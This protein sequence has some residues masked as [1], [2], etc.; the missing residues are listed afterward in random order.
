MERTRK[1]GGEGRREGRRDAEGRGTRR[2]L[3]REGGAQ[4]ALAARPC[5][6]ARSQRGLPRPS[7]RPPPPPQPLPLARVIQ[8][9]A[10][11]LRP[12]GFKERA[13][14]DFFFRRLRL[15]DTRRF[16]DAYPFV[17]PCG[18]EMNYVA[19]EDTPVVFHSLTADGACGRGRA[20]GTAGGRAGGRVG[21]R[22]ARMR[23][24]ERA[25]GRAGE[26]VGSRAKSA[27]A[28]PSA[29]QNAVWGG[30]L[31]YPFDPRTLFFG[32]NGRLYHPSPL[33]PHALVRSALALEL[34]R[35]AVPNEH[36]TLTMLWR[37]DRDRAEPIPIPTRP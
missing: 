28:N 33:G 8:T 30:Q 22:R 15:N 27:A 6:P 17:S 19:A 9:I 11:Q 26:R 36:G 16:V 32:E 21:G 4:A 18:R 7:P 5:A 14:L 10:R 29:G 12:A 3:F 20:G 37:H 2:E 23:A 25:G 34:L 35:D 13:F 1:D 31:L 24:G